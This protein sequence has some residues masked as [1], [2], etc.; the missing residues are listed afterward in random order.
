MTKAIEIE[1]KFLVATMPDLSTA[2]RSSLRQGYLTVPE[3][4]VEVRL[5]QSDDRFVLCVKTGSGIIRGERE[6]EIDGRQFDTLWP[7]TE[8]RRIEKT[9]WTGPLDDGLTFELDVFAGDLEPLA[10]VEVEFASAQQAEAFTPPDWFGRDV[11]L[12][13]R[14]GNKSL[15]ISGASFV[16]DLPDA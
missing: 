8:G 1:R 2:S 12:D 14:F 6:I 13:K 3:D 15:A 9:R 10:V 4:S 11:S 5:R 7:Q 16:K